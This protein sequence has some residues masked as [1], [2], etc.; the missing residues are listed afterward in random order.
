MFLLK[1]HIFSLSVHAG[2][3]PHRKV[4]VDKI[5]LALSAPHMPWPPSTRTPIIWTRQDVVVMH[6]MGF[7]TDQEPCGDGSH[8]KRRTFISH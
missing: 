3:T 2:D 6:A 7:W 5:S 1:N 8:A 4:A